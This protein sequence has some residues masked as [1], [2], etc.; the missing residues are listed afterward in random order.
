M[1]SSQVHF[2]GPK[3]KAEK[4]TNLCPLLN[5]VK[6]SNKCTFKGSFFYSIKILLYNWLKQYVVCFGRILPK[7]IMQ[8]SNF[9]NKV[10]RIFGFTF[11]NQNSEFSITSEFKRRKHLKSHY[12]EQI[13]GAA[14][15]Y[16][17]WCRSVCLFRMNLLLLFLLICL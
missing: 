12:Y 10:E 17:G 13:F 2:D 1:K 4:A 11:S 8:V 5:K 3:S 6:S 9:I 15:V 14:F 7:W 16:F